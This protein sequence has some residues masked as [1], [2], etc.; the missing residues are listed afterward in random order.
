MIAFVRGDPAIHLLCFFLGVPFPGVIKSGCLHG[1]ALDFLALLLKS[2]AA[3]PG[4]P[5]EGLGT[6]RDGGVQGPA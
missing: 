4:E 5:G 2:A 6:I 3:G 1:W